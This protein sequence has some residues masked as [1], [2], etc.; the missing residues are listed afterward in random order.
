MID[1]LGFINNTQFNRALKEENNRCSNPTV[2]KTM[3]GKKGLV[4]KYGKVLEKPTFLN[5]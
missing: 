2:N 1:K 5:G 3:L 4:G